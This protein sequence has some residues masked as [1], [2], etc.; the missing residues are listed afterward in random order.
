M[1]WPI[2]WWWWWCYWWW[3]WWWL[4]WCHLY[5]QINPPK[6]VLL[7]IQ[8]SWQ[9][10]S[11]LQR[12]AGVEW[13]WSE[14]IKLWES[15]PLKEFDAI[16][17]LFKSSTWS[18]LCIESEATLSFQRNWRDMHLGSFVLHL[19]LGHCWDFVGI[20]LGWPFKVPKSLG[21]I[22]TIPNPNQTPL[23]ICLNQ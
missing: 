3:W 17:L 13:W 23:K 12:T 9:D 8:P 2:Y 7:S 5:E 19:L 14:G 6:L 22:P 18:Y 16:L 15:Y 11:L 1:L 21:W 10:L 20:L 4:W